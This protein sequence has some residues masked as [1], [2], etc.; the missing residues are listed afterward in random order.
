MAGKSLGFQFKIGRAVRGRFMNYFTYAFVPAK[1]FHINKF[2]VGFQ[3]YIK[4]ATYLNSKGFFWGLEYNLMNAK[5]NNGVQMTLDPFGG[6][7]RKI[8]DQMRI[9]CRL[10]LQFNLANKNNNVG[11]NLTVGI[12]FLKRNFK[13]YYTTL[14]QKHRL[15]KN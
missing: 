11:V 4:K 13:A 3:R 15:P 5:Y 6:Y 1:P 8:N 10:A 7:D 2:G 12:H 9:H 14:N